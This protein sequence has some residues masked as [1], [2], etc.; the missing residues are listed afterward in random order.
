M[1][2]EDAEIDRGRLP[3]R[4]PAYRVELRTTLLASYAEPAL[5]EWMGV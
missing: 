2:A 5:L 3:S 1:R 4:L